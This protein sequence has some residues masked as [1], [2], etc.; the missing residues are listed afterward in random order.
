MSMNLGY[1]VGTLIFLG[2]FLLAVI[3]Q[4]RASK[5][6][7]YLYW[8][9]IVASTT[10][11][12]TMADFVDRSLGIGYA[13]G[14]SFLFTLSHSLPG[15]LALVWQRLRQHRRNAAGRSFLLDDHPDFANPRTR[16]WATGWPIPT[17]SALAAARSCSGRRLRPPPPLFL[18]PNAGAWRC[19]GPSSS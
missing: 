14:C 8:V 19:S 13:G 5:F 2:V 12:T 10:V 7:P 18:R 6:N 1:A 16:L 11:G 3:A 17:V 4:I 15:C 9:T